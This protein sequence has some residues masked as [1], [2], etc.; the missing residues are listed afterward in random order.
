MSKYD[1]YVYYKSFNT[2]NYYNDFIPIKNYGN[3]YEPKVF[4]ESE[5]ELIEK[6]ILDAFSKYSGQELI[7]QLNK[8]IQVLSDYGYTSNQ[9]KGILNQLIELNKEAILSKS[10]IE[11]LKRIEEEKRRIEEEKKRALEEKRRKVEARKKEIIDSFLN[12]I[13]NKQG[14]EN[15]RG[16]VLPNGELL[17]Q[18]SE[19][20]K[21]EGGTR[22]DHSSL[23]KTFM[24]GLE[25]YDIDAYDR[26]YA[27]YEEYLDSY[28]MKGA[29]F[30]ESFAVEVLGWMQI[31]ICGYK[32][33]LYQ[34]ERWQDR[35]LRPFLVDYGFKYHIRN[36]KG[37]YNTNGL[38][39]LYDHINEI[40]ELGLTKKY[41][42][43]LERILQ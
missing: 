29:D 2:K 32:T 28:G 7:D 20:G 31:N 19:I 41:S 26:I 27:L 4:T 34:G 24:A 43:T 17:S 42:D 33:I 25:D 14:S 16:W 23:F 5:K 9:I 8:I 3:I 6:F 30:S 39:T 1:D 10:N 15:F 38:D 22:Q 11:R 21:I 40:L 36:A 37:N 18:Y 13:T 12:D 35:I